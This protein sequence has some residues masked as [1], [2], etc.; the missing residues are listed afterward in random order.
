MAIQFT[1]TFTISAPGRKKGVLCVV[2]RIKGTTTRCVCPVQGLVAPDIKCWDQSAQRFLGG[3]QADV[4]NNNL[5]NELAQK[6]DKLANNPRVTSA[7]EFVE[8]IYREEELPPVETFGEYLRSII[9]AMR[10]GNNNK[11]P[12]RNYQTYI[13]LLH[14]LE[15]EK[16]ILE[17]PIG[18]ISNKHFIQF[19]D[20]LISLHKSTGFSNYLNL[21]K[22]FKQVHK[23]AFEQEKN[24]NILR[25]K[26]ADAAPLT[27]VNE[28]LSSMTKE[29]YM[30][31]KKL[32]LSKVL[33]SGRK[34]EFYKELYRDFCIFLYETKMRPV[35]VIKAHSS[36]LVVINDRPFLRYIAEKKKNSREK[37]KVTYTPLNHNALAI[38]KK[39][40]HASSQGYI[41][42]FSLNEYKWDF[43]NAEQWNRWNNRKA[44]ALE[45]INHW[46][47]KVS[48]A[49]NLDFVL[50]T[51]SFRRT[52]L[53][54]A[55]QDSMNYLMIA[56]EASTSPDM[57][58]KHY[59][60]NVV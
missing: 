52:A 19:S 7:N 32:D 20:F 27:E 13:N 55:C 16:N 48:Q 35:D 1:Y 57:L 25:F 26:Y 50:T 24:S 2:V 5:L 38:I 37:N 17:V 33:Q 3:T 58:L 45:M 51:Y 34:Q 31:F 41:F 30:A 56:L 36:G 42:P 43:M 14:K 12:S 29:E 23:R 47:K 60:S 49:L 40:E 44:R 9:T 6:C 22:Y 54:H 46:L 8:L 15:M 39:Y 18:E 21:M 59:V 10:T 53:S 28:K 4:D 11:R